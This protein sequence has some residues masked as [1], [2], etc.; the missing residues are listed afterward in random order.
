MQNKNIIMPYST[1]AYSIWV[2]CFMTFWNITKLYKLEWPDFC[3]LHWW[4][5]ATMHKAKFVFIID[6]LIWFFYIWYE[7]TKKKKTWQLAADS[8]FLSFKYILVN[9]TSNFMEFL[10]ARYV[11]LAIHVHFLRF[12][13]IFA[14]LKSSYYFIACFNSFRWNKW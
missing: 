1:I 8:E 5:V 2:S 11:L 4:I 9:I 13:N 7:L 14:N 10:Y 6:D 12:Q 3:R